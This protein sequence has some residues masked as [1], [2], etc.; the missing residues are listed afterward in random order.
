MSAFKSFQRPSLRASSPAA[1]AFHNY[2]PGFGDDDSDGVSH[3]KDTTRIY[4]IQQLDTFV[5]VVDVIPHPYR[6]VIRPGLNV[7]AKLSDKLE[8]AKSALEG[9]QAHEAKHTWPAQL[10]GVSVPQFQCS[11]EFDATNEAGEHRA[12]FEKTTL[13]YKVATLKRAITLKSDEVKDLT[14]QLHP[15]TWLSEFKK[16]V[17]DAYEKGPKKEFIPTVAWN[18]PNNHDLGSTIKYIEDPRTCLVFTQVMNE[19]IYVGHAV[20]RISNT[21]REIAKDIAAKKEKLK[22]KGDV[23]MTDGTG[24][25]GPSSDKIEDLVAKAVEKRLKV[26]TSPPRCTRAKYNLG[27]AEASQRGEDFQARP[28]PPYQTSP[29]NLGKGKA[30]AGGSSQKPST[31]KNAGSGGGQSSKGTKRKVSENAQQSKG[32]KSKN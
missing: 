10:M 15:E 30:P 21:K 2:A 9:L 19:L 7:L 25:A 23:E 13:D 20:I 24:A 12:W 27:T 1:A 5:E 6:E 3:S 22:Q 31:A 17:M 18:D 8:K 28:A 16:T 14:A 32:K 11:S 4:M 26:R 29:K